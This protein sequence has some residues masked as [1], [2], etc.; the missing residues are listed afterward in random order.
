MKRTTLLFASFLF[1]I[2]SFVF[3][4]CIAD[5]QDDGAI[6]FSDDFESGALSKWDQAAKQ[7]EI[8]GDPEHVLHGKYSAVAIAKEGEGTGG[9][10]VQWFMPGYDKVYARWYCKFA[11]DFDQGNHMHFCHLLANRWDN[12]WSASGK[13]GIRPSG[14]DFF[15]TGL[16]PWRDWGRNPAPGA[17]GFYTY[18]M[19]MPKDAKMDKYWGDM[20]KPEPKF[21]LKRGQWYC[22]EMM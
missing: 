20:F 18:H 10:L 13:A 19:D 2:L 15:T 4:V 17:M 5:A 3:F 14:D 16:E 21:V 1:F 9:K 22:M 8:T 6:I 7:M 12:K 11:E